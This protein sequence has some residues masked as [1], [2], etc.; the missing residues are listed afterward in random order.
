MPV[1]VA[2]GHSTNM[3]YHRVATLWE[4][5][6][7]DC[8]TEY[9]ASL[10]KRMEVTAS[11]FD[12]VIEGLFLQEVSHKFELELHEE[13]V[14]IVAASIKDEASLSKAGCMR[15][16]FV[17]LGRTL[18]DVEN[19]SKQRHG[20]TE[21]KFT[22]ELLSKLHEVLDPGFRRGLAL[23]AKL[24]NTSDVA[25]RE[26][27]IGLIKVQIEVLHNRCEETLER[28]TEATMKYDARATRTRREFE[29]VCAAAVYYSKVGVEV[30]D[31]VEA[32]AREQVARS[33]IKFAPLKHEYREELLAKLSENETKC[34]ERSPLGKWISFFDVLG[35]NFWSD[36]EGN[37]SGKGKG[38]DDESEYDD[39]ILESSD[40]EE[41][42]KMTYPRKSSAT[43]SAPSG[44]KPRP[45][46]RPRVLR[47]P[48]IESCVIPKVSIRDFKDLDPTPTFFA[49]VETFL[50]QDFTP[51]DDGGP[52]QHR[53]LDYHSPPRLVTTDVTGAVDIKGF[54]R[55]NLNLNDQRNYAKRISS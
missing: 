1:E 23:S 33:M 44:F 49:E 50:P 39:Y 53:R 18:E 28:K 47:E 40:D 22:N 48:P 31:I 51:W 24:A 41:G 7:W 42:K 30:D 37:T 9:Y 34:D 13:L 55:A 8:V 19:R 38:S 17:V 29:S 32:Q 52:R 10:I 43:K 25:A 20:K 3:S 16:P 4:L 27:E 11:D 6:D 35:D 15:A 46:P 21:N 45:E 26:C 12:D 5:G 36:T 2:Q 54:K 14:A